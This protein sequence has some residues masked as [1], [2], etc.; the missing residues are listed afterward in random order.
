MDPFAHA[1]SGALLG[2]AAV[3][4]GDAWRAALGFGVV[5]AMAPDVDAP[6]ALLGPEAWARWHQ[7]W[8][9][10]L[11]G[12]VWV[13]LLVSA[14]PFRFARW[15]TRY[16][17][18]L[19]GWALHVV[20]DAVGRWPVP[21]AWPLSAERFGWPLLERDFSWT[22]DML[23]VAGLAASL[24]DRALAQARWI[25]GATALAVALWLGLGLPT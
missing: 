18:A 21:L 15:R 11:V 14:L 25:A 5:A 1:A 8:T 16:G 23:I 2:R 20:L 12:L 24:W 13:P 6:L 4:T 7:V 9:H 10:S 19:A 3:P 22:V 17:V